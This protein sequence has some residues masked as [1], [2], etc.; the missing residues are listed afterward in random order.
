MAYE[1]VVSYRFLFTYKSACFDWLLFWM[2]F[3]TIGVSN[4]T[5]VLTSIDGRKTQLLAEFGLLGM[6]TIGSLQ[7]RFVTE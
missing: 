3:T 2:T 1:V 6:T 4:C 7:S 5:G